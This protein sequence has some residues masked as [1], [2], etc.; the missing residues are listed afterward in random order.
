MATTPTPADFKVSDL[1]DTLFG[2]VFFTVKDG[3]GSS[4]VLVFKTPADVRSFAQEVDA[5]AVAYIAATDES[6][7]PDGA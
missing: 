2:D 3:V 6:V 4:H 5:E 7:F 1:N